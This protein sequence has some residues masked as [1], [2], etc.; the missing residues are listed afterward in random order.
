MS[1][2]EAAIFVY[3]WPEPESSAA[4]VRTVGLCRDLQALGYSVSAFSPCRENAASA[5]LAA[6]GVSTIP[7]PANDSAAEE[8]FRQHAPSLVLYDR[9]VMEEQFGWRARAAWPEALHIVDTQ[10]LHSL[11]RA[12]ERLLLAG[13]RED[14]LEEKDFSPDIEREL[15]SLYRSDA[16][17]VVSNWEREW[18][19]ARDYPADRVFYLPFGAAP[20]EETPPFAERSGFAFL[21]NFRHPPNL[22]AVNYLVAELWPRLQERL[23]G[24]SLFLYG[25]YPPASVSG[26]HGKNGIQVVGPVKDHRAALKKHRALLA[27]LRFGAGLKGKVLEAWACGTPVA[28][29]AIAMESLSYP[30]FAEDLLEEAVRLHESQAHWQNAQA[31]SL[32]ALKPFHPIRL[33]EE[34]RGV[35]ATAEKEKTY[36]RENLVSRML[37]HHQQNST[38][39]FSRW[40]EAKQKK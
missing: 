5:A 31:S 11:R 16:C 1:L 34:L 29:S 30:F 39:Y 38:K 36:W 22:D 19:L 21:G 9:F 3:V 20:E 27:P 25:A 28:G 7:C 4:G 2:M 6:L 8:I 32:E 37:R 17:L 12:R 14:S 13:R 24:A 15:A 35:L 23:P 33:R 40:I 10:D 26:L 18:L